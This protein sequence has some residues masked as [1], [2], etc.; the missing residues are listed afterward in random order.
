MQNL[1]QETALIVIDI[2]EGFDDPY[3]GPRNNPDAE[4][5]IARLLVAWRRTGRPVIHTRHDSRNPKSPLYP[6]QPGNDIKEIARPAGGEAVLRKSVNS[7]FIGTGLEE[8]LRKEGITSVVVTGINTNHC[9]STT[10]RM[11]GNLGFSTLVVADATATFDMSGPDG[12]RY[13][14]AEMHRF[15]LAEIHGEFATI[16]ETDALLKVV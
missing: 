13:T 2:Q 4:D 6:G 14:A 11:A 10:A 12:H 1:P 7:A 15:G 5:N 8:R 9:V 3:W 16:V